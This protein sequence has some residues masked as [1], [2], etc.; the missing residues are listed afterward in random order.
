MF[1]WTDGWIG[2]RCIDYL[3][4]HDPHGCSLSTFCSRTAA[5]LNF[6]STSNQVSADFFFF[7]SPRALVHSRNLCLLGPGSLAFLLLGK[8]RT[9]APPH[10]VKAEVST[11]LE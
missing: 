4:F 5:C 7:F 6:V 9:S 10:Q 11:W 2:A 1:E 3:R 8:G